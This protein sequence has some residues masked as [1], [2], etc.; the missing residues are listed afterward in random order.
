MTAEIKEKL[1]KLC[2]NELIDLLFYEFYTKIQYIEQGLLV[3]RRTAVTYLQTLEREG[4]LVSEKIGTER[5]CQNK[6]L[7]D[8][9]KYQRK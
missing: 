9:V 4:F 2:T 7:Y 6:R 8:L 3:S 1:P 5:I